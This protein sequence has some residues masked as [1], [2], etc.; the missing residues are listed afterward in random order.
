[1]NNKED[2]SNSYKYEDLVV[3]R[4]DVPSFAFKTEP[5]FCDK[6]GDSCM[7]DGVNYVGVEVDVTGLPKSLQDKVNKPRF[8]LCYPCWLNSVM[9][10]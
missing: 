10:G 2:A 1:M 3:N 9:G 6:C 5:V 4:D 7:H 8:S